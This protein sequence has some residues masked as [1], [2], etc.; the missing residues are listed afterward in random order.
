MKYEWE[1]EP[2]PECD[3]FQFL[4]VEE[5]DKHKWCKSDGPRTIQEP[6]KQPL[7]PSRRDLIT[8]VHIVEIGTYGAYIAKDLGT[9][10]HYSVDETQCEK[11]KCDC[12]RHGIPFSVY[13]RNDQSSSS[14]ILSVFNLGCCDVNPELK[15]LVDGIDWGDLFDDYLSRVYAGKEKRDQGKNNSRAPIRETSRNADQRSYGFSSGHSLSRDPLDGDMKPHLIDK[16]VPP[17]W[18][19]R[20]AVMT[21]VGNA[22]FEHP[23]CD[24]LRCGGSGP[25]Y[26]DKARRLAF[27]ATI[28]EDNAVEALTLSESKRKSLLRCH[29]DANNDDT[30]AW[31]DAKYNHVVSA[32]KCFVCP[33]GSV[34]RITVIAYSRRSIGDYIDRERKCTNFIT[35]RLLPW[36]NELDDSRKETDLCCDVFSPAYHEDTGEVKLESGTMFIAPCTNKQGTYLSAYV[37]QFL[38][39]SCGKGTQKASPGNILTF[40]RYRFERPCQTRELR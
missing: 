37:D 31:V 3:P 9:H 17:A 28:H 30:T 27:A 13:S 33:D 38:K 11:L 24:R 29:T 12:E 14:S 39:V 18:A 7:H 40:P 8:R 16:D 25:L 35:N 32:W 10:P 1:H 34:V 6:H 2:L 20:F 22:L 26:D 23:E 5:M 19:E 36:Y 15:Q 4:V 21:K